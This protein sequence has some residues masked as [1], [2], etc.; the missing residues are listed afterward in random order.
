[1]TRTDQRFVA[2][3]ERRLP[4][5]FNCI[6]RCALAV[7]PALLQRWLPGGRKEGNEYVALN[8]TRLDRRLGSF[9]INMRTGRWADFATGDR[10]G[11]VVS[12]A[13]YL[14]HLKQREA[15]E[16]LADMLGVEAR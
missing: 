15:A 7:L 9:R 14:S 11:D 4:V 3:A 13:A 6:N 12:L 10:G 16:K 1:M 2:M 8:P 5:D